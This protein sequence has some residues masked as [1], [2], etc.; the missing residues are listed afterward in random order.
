MTRLLVLK[1]KYGTRMFDVST[2]Q[3]LCQVALYV[4]TTRFKDGYW[5]DDPGDPPAPLDFE[6]KDIEGMPASLRADAKKQVEQ[7]K[8]NLAEHREQKA[9]YEE[10]K[11]AVE[12]KNGPLAWQILH[13]RSRYEYEQAEM[14]YCEQPGDLPQIKWPPLDV[15]TQV[16]TARRS[17]TSKRDA[18]ELG[19]P[20]DLIAGRRWGAAGGIDGFRDDSGLWYKVAHEG[21]G[22]GCYRPSE[23]R[24]KET[25]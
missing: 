21:G 6:E 16:V 25:S 22:F 17:L 8:R 24:P 15:G 3:R 4:L 10:I 18:E 5:Y 14:E 13:A 19:W 1:E 11:R 23:L 9:D 12:E 2:D 20:A 7:H